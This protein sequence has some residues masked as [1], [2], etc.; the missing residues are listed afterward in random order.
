MIIL[1]QVKFVLKD[2]AQFRLC[3][4][5][6]NRIMERQRLRMD[7]IDGK[8]DVYVIRVV[9]SDAHSLMFSVAK[10]R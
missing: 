7:L 9:M 3:L 8:V 2:H 1:S 5:I 10:P 6:P 4:I